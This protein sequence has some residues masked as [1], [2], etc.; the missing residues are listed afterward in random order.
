MVHANIATRLYL[1]VTHINELARHATALAIR[2]TAFTHAALPS[3]I[4]PIPDATDS[5]T[6]SVLPH[7]PHLPSCHTSSVTPSTLARSTLN[8]SNIHTSA[9]IEAESRFTVLAEVVQKLPGF[10]NTPR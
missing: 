2:Y 6:V 4:G 7:R 9:I 5:G 10:R 8:R 3:Q 1:D